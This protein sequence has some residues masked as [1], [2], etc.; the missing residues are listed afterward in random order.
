MRSVIEKYCKKKLQLQETQKKWKKACL[1]YSDA[2]KKVYNLENDLQSHKQHVERLTKIN[3]ELQQSYEY[4]E[5]AKLAFKAHVVQLQVLMKNHEQRIENL[6]SE[7]KAASDKD[8]KLQ[9]EYNKKLLASEHQ[10]K[11]LLHHIQIFR[12]LIIENKRPNKQQKKIL[13]KYEK[14]QDLSDTSD[15]NDNE[16]HVE[17]DIDISDVLRDKHKELSMAAEKVKETRLTMAVRIATGAVAHIG[18]NEG[19]AIGCRLRHNFPRNIG[20]RFLPYKAM[21]LFPGRVLGRC[22]VQPESVARSL[23]HRPCMRY[24]R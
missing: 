1:D 6:K 12:N 2:L 20:R 14:S 22:R 23:T 16:N 15:F 9:Q 4:A 19:F 18:G 7:N 3:G 24:K 10:N 17:S 21:Y 13:K 11:Q 8:I 5:T